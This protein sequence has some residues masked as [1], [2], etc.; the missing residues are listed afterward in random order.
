[1]KKFKLKMIEGTKL[2]VTRVRIVLNEEDNENGMGMETGH[3]NVLGF[4][5]FYKLNE[6]EY[7]DVKEFFDRKNEDH[8]ENQLVYHIL[9]ERLKNHELFIQNPKPFYTYAHCVRVL[10]RPED[11]KEYADFVADYF[12]KHM[13][14]EKKWFAAKDYVHKVHHKNDETIFMK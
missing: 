7:L 6:N 11:V 4:R 3:Y 2:F 1:M 9:S 14:D 10:E 8:K 13:H 12:N 5:L